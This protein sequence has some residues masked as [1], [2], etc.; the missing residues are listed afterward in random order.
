MRGHEARQRGTPPATTKAHGQ[1]PSSDGRRVPQS[2]RARTT[3]NEPRHTNRC[4]A[5]ANPHK[6]GRQPQNKLM[7]L[8]TFKK[9]ANPH[10]TNPGQERRGAAKTRA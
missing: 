7:R 4:Q 6:G 5:T 9:T 10:T 3:R 2:L 1:V 8:R